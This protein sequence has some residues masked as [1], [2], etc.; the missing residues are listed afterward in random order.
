MATHDEN[1]VNRLKK[2]VIAFQNKE[3]LSDLENGNYILK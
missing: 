1:V 2:R 3:I